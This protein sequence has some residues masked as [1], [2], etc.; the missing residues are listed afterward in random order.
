MNKDS[1]VLALFL[2]FVLPFIVAA[3]DDDT[4]AQLR[5]NPDIEVSASTSSFDYSQYKFL[6]LE[7]NHIVMNGDDWSGLAQ[8]FAA[9][10]N[11]D[12]LFSV[13]YL[14]D[15]HVQADF[16]GA[17]IRQRLQNETRNAGRGIVIPFRLAGTNQPFDYSFSLQKPYTASKLLKQ[18]WA[19]EILFTGIG[20]KPSNS[21]YTLGIHCDMPFSKMRFFYNGSSP[22]LN[23]ADAD[24]EIL[25]TITIDSLGIF[26]LNFGRSLSDV[27]VEFDG[28]CSTVFG[29]VELM[30]DSVGTVIHS[31]GNNGA[32]YSSYANIEGFGRG[33]AGLNPD[34][35]IVALGTN[36][37]FGRTTTDAFHADMD[38]LL[39]AIRHANPKS[40]I[41]LVGPTECYKKT[42]RRVQGKNGRRR[43]VSRTV[44]NTKAKTI[45]EAILDYSETENIPYY[46]HYT[47]AGGEGAAAKMK[48]AKILGKDG[49]HFT[50]SGYQLWGNLISDAIIEALKFSSNTNL[51]KK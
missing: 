15:S 4:Q 24:G 42:Y 27:A 47:I 28:D 36:E 1:F 20:L 29:G 33:L 38:A 7:S 46:D 23:K 18:P 5:E 9:A 12:S 8:K 10:A 35:V 40:K 30:N 19:T 31:I 51:A 45:H 26:T 34:L 48:S 13:V 37:A 11:G 14:G 21:N 2:I 50:A 39:G 44:V 17:V 43:R 49:I 32:T 16:G 6:K 22:M 25:S 3:Q 41:L